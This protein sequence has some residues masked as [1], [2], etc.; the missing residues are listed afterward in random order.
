MNIA[1]LNKYLVTIFALTCAL[2]ALPAQAVQRQAMVKAARKA[3]P[4]ML[5]VYISQK[6]FQ[7]VPAEKQAVF[8]A[9]LEISRHS[10]S[11][12]KFVN[13]SGKFII[14][15]GEAPRLMRTSEDPNGPVFVNAELLNQDS[16]EY[17][18]PFLIKTLCHEF[19]HKIGNVP[20]DLR[21]R[22]AQDL[23]DFLSPDWKQDFETTENGER[24]LVFSL[25]NDKIQTSLNH[26]SRDSLQPTFYVFVQH[27]G[28]I[29]DI[30]SVL[31]QRTENSTA[32]F[33]ST[34]SIASHM[35]FGLFQGMSGLMSE[36]SKAL[37]PVMQ[38]L[39]S[40]FGAKPP[41]TTFK[42]ALGTP[43]EPMHE[44]KL[45][46]IQ[47]A[48]LHTVAGRPGQVFL[49]L[50]GVFERARSHRRI[51]LNAGGLAVP[52]SYPV[53]VTLA[54]VLSLREGAKASD[55]R[56][57]PRAAPDFKDT[58]KVK[59][60]QRQQGAVSKLT[61][62]VKSSAPLK[63]AEMMAY[64]RGGS[65][66]YPLTLQ[67]QANGTYLATFEPGP[68]F[69][70]APFTMITDSLL[71]N[72][73]D[74]VFLDR[75]ID[76]N[77]GR[78]DQ[79]PPPAATGI[80]PDSIGLWGIHGREQ[81]LQKAF[82]SQNPPIFMDGVSSRVFF[83]KPSDLP[84]EF[85]TEA[86]MKIRQIRLFWS[87]ALF[88]VE[89]DREEAKAK[90]HEHPMF[91]ILIDGKRRRFTGG[92][93]KVRER[94]DIYETIT[95]DQ[96]HIHYLQ[97][98]TPGRQRVIGRIQ[99]P[100]K[101]LREELADNEA[102]FPAQVIPMMVEIVTDDYRTFTHYFPS[103]DQEIKCDDLLKA[104]FLNPERNSQEQ[105]QSGDGRPK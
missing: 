33:K 73:E 16:L 1:S 49:D 23:E 24:L 42:D 102:F 40:A 83:L 46:Q 39:A 68:E 98:H 29:D 21:D 41:E 51:K 27:E 14:T 26:A 19:S 74:A 47:D 28:R 55:L 67:P 63:K 95:F 72:S 15:E 60:I 38:A 86:G 58:A 18:L 77:E 6:D 22:V 64:Y 61:F 82:G 69:A 54:G 75:L 7:N 43:G 31:Y 50:K 100:Y 53:P 36:F 56:I 104:S 94:R 76:L 13:D 79:A 87:R 93:S 2:V 5:Q 48:E 88:F 44:L 85:E 4:D 105:D 80:A 32:L 3:L 11:E 59:G 103:T 84:L 45:L 97:S 8:K 35:V 65:L 25:A 9:L 12:L 52:D 81:Q 92:S 10:I 70:A 99:V 20:L 90:P 30:T 101:F 96:A 78:N 89:F 34:W 37:D 62:E 57:T 17:S 71:L 66:L 91:E